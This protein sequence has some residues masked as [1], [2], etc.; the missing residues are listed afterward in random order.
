MPNHH[1]ISRNSRR[2]FLQTLGS[3]A[4]AIPFL[5]GCVTQEQ[6]RQLVEKVLEQL[7]GGL[8]RSPK[9]NAWLEVLADGRVRIF[10]GK[11]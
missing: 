7:P 2:Q 3:L 1:P 6:E 4:I 5:P 11:V 9:V 10:S 8:R